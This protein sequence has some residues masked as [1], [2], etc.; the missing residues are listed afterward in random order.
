M[1]FEAVT[2]SICRVHSIFVVVDLAWQ[3]YGHLSFQTHG[4]PDEQSYKVRWEI[5][6]DA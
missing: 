6:A 1:E 2:D 5:W 4:V 3:T